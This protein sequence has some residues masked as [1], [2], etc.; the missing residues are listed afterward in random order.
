MIL[1]NSVFAVT[2]LVKLSVPV[3]TTTFFRFTYSIFGSRAIL[4]RGRPLYFS[5]LQK[6][7][8]KT[9]ETMCTSAPSARAVTAQHDET[10]NQLNRSTFPRQQALSPFLL[11]PTERQLEIVAQL[12]LNGD[13]GLLQLSLTWR[14]FFQITTEPD[15]ATLLRI[16][17]SP[18]AR[19][20]SL[21]SCRYC[22]R[23]G[24]KKRSGQ[25]T[26]RSNP[27]LASL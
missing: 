19:T 21:L 18:S 2:A 25:W 9:S 16:E 6:K 23:L 11:L 12:E 4:H 24:L 20:H 26:Q 8:S 7:H 5:N 15:Y 13:P 3:V 17:Q 14:Y 1:V 10:H 27:L 22:A